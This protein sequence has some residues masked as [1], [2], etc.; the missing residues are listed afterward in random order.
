MFL[1]NVAL[2]I[3][4]GVI[5][6]LIAIFIISYLVNKKT[7]VPKGCEELKVTE[8]G[9]MACHNSDCSVRQKLDVKKLE[10]E[11]HK[12]EEELKEEEK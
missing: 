6:L 1:F 2:P 5:V 4:I 7:P 11:L 10:E 8:E 3:A 9:C 12:I